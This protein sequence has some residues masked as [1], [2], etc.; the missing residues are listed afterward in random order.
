MRN[1]L[2][3]RQKELRA[4]REM[5]NFE[6]VAPRKLLDASSRPGGLRRMQLGADGLDAAHHLVTQRQE[7]AVERRARRAR[8][9]RVGA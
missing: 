4:A 9:R 7:L 2:R 8:R 1:G 3:P 6:R 5:C